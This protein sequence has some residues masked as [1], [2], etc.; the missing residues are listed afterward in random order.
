MRSK[1]KVTGQDCKDMLALESM[2]EGF[3]VESIPCI[4]CSLLIDRGRSIL[5]FKVRG[6][7]IL[8]LTLMPPVRL[9]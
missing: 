7:K 9:A 1:S 5:I 8:K 4:V 6:L 3:Y 2:C